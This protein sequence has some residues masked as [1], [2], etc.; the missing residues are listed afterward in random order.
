M[1]EDRFALR[2]K[3]EDRRQKTREGEKSGASMRCDFSF[4]LLSNE[5]IWRKIRSDGAGM[6]GPQRW[7]PGLSRTVPMPMRGRNTGAYQGCQPGEARAA[8]VRGAE[9]GGFS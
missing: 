2:Q 1:T 7:V 4:C 3:T 5:S 8:T 9:W 6:A